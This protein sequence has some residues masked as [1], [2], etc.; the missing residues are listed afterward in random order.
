MYVG[1]QGT[2]DGLALRLSVSH[3]SDARHSYRIGVFLVHSSAYSSRQ[4]AERAYV[5]ARKLPKVDHSSGS[6]EKAQD[7]AGVIEM[8]PISHR[9]TST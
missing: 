4:G 5:L 1:M 8:C 6:S 9:R 3:K 7:S 2:T